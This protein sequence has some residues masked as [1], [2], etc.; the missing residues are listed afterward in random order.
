MEQILILTIA[1]TGNI[2]LFKVNSRKLEKGVEY[3]QSHSCEY[4]RSGVFIVNF[5]RISQLF[6]VPQLLTLNK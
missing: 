5:E 6:V 2:Y 3:V 4:V 1:S